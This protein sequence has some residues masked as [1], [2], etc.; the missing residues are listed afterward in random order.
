MKHLFQAVFAKLTLP[1]HGRWNAFMHAKLW[2]P[3]QLEETKSQPENVLRIAN[4][5]VYTQIILGSTGSSD[6]AHNGRHMTDRR[7]AY[8]GSPIETELAELWP[9]RCWDA[10][11]RGH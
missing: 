4:V 6:G 2:K 5:I 9:C 10:W 11:N 3:H 7:S 8:R 1:V